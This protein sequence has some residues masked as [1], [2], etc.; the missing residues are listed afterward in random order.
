[1]PEF[2]IVVIGVT[3]EGLAAAHAARTLGAKVALVEHGTF[4]GEEL[5][6]GRIPIGA[7]IKAAHVFSQCRESME[8]GIRSDNIRVTWSAVKLRIADVQDDLRNLWRSQLKENGIELL[9]GTA[10]FEDANTLHIEGKNGPQALHTA[11]YILATGRVPGQPQVAGLAETGYLTPAQFFTLPEMPRSL[12]ILG[13]DARAVELS[14]AMARLGCK[15]T[16][17]HGDTTLLPK[18]DQDI[19]AFAEKLLLQE[20]VTLH[21]RA[22]IQCTRLEGEKKQLVF[23]VD[24]QA[25][26]AESRHILPLDENLLDLDSLNPEAIGITGDFSAIQCD[27]YL[28]AAPN[29]WVCGTLANPQAEASG[30]L[31]ARNA[32]TG[33]PQTVAQHPTARILFTDPGIAAIGLS[34]ARAREQ[35]SDVQIFQR[36]FSHHE[37]AVIEGETRGFVKLVTGNKG[38]I[39]G[40]HIAGQNAGDLLMPFIVALQQ[41]E[42]APKWATFATSNATLSDAVQ[43]VLAE[44]AAAVSGE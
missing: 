8:F 37:R 1:M 36:K 4:G 24:G 11:K 40:A 13:N 12:T 9:K 20:G 39:L 25:Q 17:V 32:L 3:R 26:Q 10:R 23:E 43:R 30:A 22:T 35:W 6:A 21:A 31:A 7:L 2:D 38:R 41:N 14:F 42:N 34:E 33:S 19:S 28:Q 44:Y 29:V 15:V 27:E 5:A 18:E 16:L